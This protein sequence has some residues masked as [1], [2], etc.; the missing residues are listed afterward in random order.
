LQESAF[1]S[2]HLYAAAASR[3]FAKSAV[4]FIAVLL[5]ALVVLPLVSGNA[6]LLVAR[7]L[8]VALGF[9]TAYDEFGRAL[10]WRAA[11]EQAEAVDRRLEKLDVT[12]VEPALGVFGDYSVAT[13]TA[14]PIPT[15]LYK[16]QQN[17]LNKGWEE[18]KIEIQNK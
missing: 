13:A 3:S 1:W 16:K 18:R 14:P 8:V 9:I 2:K 17:R 7:T 11:A 6:Q 15:A 5:I 4:L 12:S 10:A